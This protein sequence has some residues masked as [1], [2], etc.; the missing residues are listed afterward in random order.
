MV[1][2]TIRGIIDA[3]TPA[4]DQMVAVAVDDPARKPQEAS[5]PYKY[6]VGAGGIVISAFTETDAGPP[7]KGHPA[8]FD[9]AGSGK[10]R[11]AASTAVY[12]VTGYSGFAIDSTSADRAA[13]TARADNK[14][15]IN[16]ECNLRIMGVAYD[17]ISSVQMTSACTD[18]H[19]NARI[20]V[21]MSGV[22]TIPVPYRATQTEMQ[23]QNAHIGDAVLVNV[24][25]QP[26]F[27]FTGDPEEFTGWAV[28]FV[29]RTTWTAFL[30]TPNDANTRAVATAAFGVAVQGKYFQTAAAAAPKL[31]RLL[32]GYVQDTGG[33]VANEVRV[34]L[35]LHPRSHAAAIRNAGLQAGMLDTD[36]GAVS[37]G[38][39]KRARTGP[40]KST[41]G[42]VVQA[43]FDKI[44]EAPGGATGAQASFLGLVGSAVQPNGTVGTVP[45]AAVD[46]ST[47]ARVMA[48]NGNAAAGLGDDG[49]TATP[50]TFAGELLMAGAPDPRSRGKLA[51]RTRIAEAYLG[52][53][54][55][56]VPP[57]AVWSPSPG[58]TSEVA[59]TPHEVVVSLGLHADTGPRA[60]VPAPKTIDIAAADGSLVSAAAAGQT[61]DVYPDTA[62]AK[63]FAQNDLPEALRLV[64]GK[65]ATQLSPGAQSRIVDAA[66]AAIHAS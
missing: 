31:M 66:H 14:R 27:K 34:Q 3:P 20:A 47:A 50:G 22:A 38:A 54:T 61:I 29:P 4:A 1:T 40:A 13:L 7:V 59:N 49:E 51:A 63:R 55:P 30:A 52:G 41:F 12:E 8:V 65:M 33:R 44:P 37:A 53:A 26:N 6:Y 23:M 17:G 24:F 48:S 18:P 21:M 25:T 11:R 43:E 32:L 35:Q 2:T 57:G 64:R 28:G 19:A 9:G 36:S 10:K 62:G 15:I 45:Y 16:D 39:P 5:K 56:T 46:G 42:Q 58:N 60:W